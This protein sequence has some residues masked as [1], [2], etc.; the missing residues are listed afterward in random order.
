MDDAQSF[1]FDAVKTGACQDQTPCLGQTHT[2]HHE[3]R[4]LCGW[5][6]K[7]CLGHA[8]LRSGIGNSDVGH[9][10]EAKSAAQNSALK[11]GDDC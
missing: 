2:S 9:T 3:R 1:S 8:K 5:H 10:S 4:N 6:A 11:T 7:T